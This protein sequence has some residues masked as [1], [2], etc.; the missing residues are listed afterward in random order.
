MFKGAEGYFSANV[1]VRVV[2]YMASQAENSLDTWHVSQAR[3]HS[4][5]SG[6]ACG[7]DSSA[8]IQARIGHKGGK[9][10]TLG[11]TD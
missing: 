9:T 10:K 3:L 2:V 1:A 7:I 5:S 4:I 6:A 8:D 11:T